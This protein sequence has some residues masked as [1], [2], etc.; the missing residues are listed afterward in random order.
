MVE[1]GANVLDMNIRL[2]FVG[3]D[4]SDLRIEHATHVPFS[5]G[6]GRIDFDRKTRILTGC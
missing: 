4:L 6:W 2:D 3:G 1:H 5:Y